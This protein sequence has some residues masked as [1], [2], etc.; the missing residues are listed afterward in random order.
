MIRERLEA[1]LRPNADG[2]LPCPNQGCG[3]VDIERKNDSDGYR[4]IECQLCGCMS[5]DTPSMNAFDRWNHRPYTRA[6]LTA[7]EQR[8]SFA[9]RHADSFDDMSGE[10]PECDARLLAIL[11]GKE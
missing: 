7:I 8:N 6:L 1:M 3:S 9:T 2:L 10:I 5:Y 11:E 4:I